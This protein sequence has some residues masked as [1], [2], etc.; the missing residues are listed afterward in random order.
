MIV[1]LTPTGARGVQFGLC[2][3]YMERQTYTGEVTWI[4][5]DDAIPRTTDQVKDGFKANWHIVKINP[6]PVWQ[7]G[8]NTQSRNMTAGLDYAQTLPGVEAIFI[9]EDDDYYRPTYLER[10]MSRLGHFKVLGEA[11]TVYYNVVYRTYFV[12][13][14][15]SYSSLFQIAFTPDMIPLFKKCFYERF[16]DLKFFKELRIQ[17]FVHRREVGLFNENNL[18]I[19]MKGIPGRLGIGE[20]H[21]FLSNMLPDPNLVYLNQIIGDDAKYYEGYY[22]NMHRPQHPDAFRRRI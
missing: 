4:I 9:I 1:L 21:T 16:I 14:N 17:G 12:H 6:N 20:G 3:L 19:G 13:D 7:Q 2:A 22:G 8:Q 18:A 10:M 15:T 5:V 11:N